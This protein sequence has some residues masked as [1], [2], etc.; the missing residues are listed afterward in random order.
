MNVGA[1]PSRRPRPAPRQVTHC[2]HRTP[3]D[4]VASGQARRR[5]LSGSPYRRRAC[6][7][8]SHKRIS[9]ITAWLAVRS[10]WSRPAT[11]SGVACV[12]VAVVGAATLAVPIAFKARLDPTTDETL[13]RTFERRFTLRVAVAQSAA[14]AGWCGAFASKRWSP[15]AIG[16]SFWVAGFVRLTPTSRSLA[17]D[18]SDIELRTPGRSLVHALRRTGA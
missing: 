3:V 12:A 4:A 2:L 14:I 13:A 9:G 17:A 16:A 15:Y 8:A 18:Q 11:R 10:R 1:A 7:A 6:R 5:R